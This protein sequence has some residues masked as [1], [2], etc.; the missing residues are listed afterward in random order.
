MEKI[1]YLLLLSFLW[2]SCN[3]LFADSPLTST[4]FYKAYQHEKMVV[5]AAATDGVLTNQLIKFLLAKKKPIA[6]KMA[7]INRLGWSLDG[8][9]NAS[10]FFDYLQ[11]HKG[12]KGTDDLLKRAGASELLCMAYLKAMDNYFEVDEAIV[13]AEK[14]VSKNPKSFTY[15]II[16]ALIKA[17]KAMDGDWCMVF[18]ITDRVRK[19]KS[20]QMDMKQEAFNII[21]EYMDLYQDD[22]DD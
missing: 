8:K 22:C 2:I 11:E 15:N 9:Q 7:V 21:F 12:Y 20:L 6:V 18:K 4:D 5:R 19:D 14:A 13:Y 10:V 1:K 3:P 17:Q 16:C